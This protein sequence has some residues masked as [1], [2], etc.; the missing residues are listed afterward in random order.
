SSRSWPGANGCRPSSGP[1]PSPSPSPRP[2]SS[3]SPR[4]PSSPSSRPS[5]SPPP[6]KPFAVDRRPARPAGHA[7][8]C[9][10][11][12]A[13]VRASGPGEEDPSHWSRSGAGEGARPAPYH[14]SRYLPAPSLDSSAPRSSRAMS[15]GKS[16]IQQAVDAAV[17]A[18]STSN[19]D[20]L[21][22]AAAEG[23]LEREDVTAWCDRVLRIV[24]HRRERAALAAEIPD[25]AHWLGR[26]LAGVPLPA[27]VDAEGVVA[28]F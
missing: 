28:A 21:A 24:L 11:R 13:P 10:E 14:G 8:P 5:W 25:L 19:G 22:K 4:P 16:R 12:P 2:P 1:K 6:R 26:I 18:L 7:K 27:G 20:A 23:L 15:S 3:P 9:R 17:A